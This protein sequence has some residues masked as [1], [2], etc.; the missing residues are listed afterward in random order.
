MFGVL[1]P[2]LLVVVF[3]CFLF[4]ANFLFWRISNV[5][6]CN[7]SIG[8]PGWL[9]RQSMQL[10]ISGSLNPTLSVELTLKKGGDIINTHSLIKQ[11][12]ELL[13]HAESYF[14]Y[15]LSANTPSFVIL[16][17]IPDII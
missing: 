10:S 14:I 12:H 9:S 8:V 7:N 6:K 17:Q 3:L 11:F 5:Q 2:P 4:K 15:A 13:T 1:P 16:K